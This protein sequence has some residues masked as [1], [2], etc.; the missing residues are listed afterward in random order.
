MATHRES[1]PEPSPNA[2]PDTGD[3]LRWDEGAWDE[4]VWADDDGDGD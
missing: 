3:D 4:G 1:G 2:E